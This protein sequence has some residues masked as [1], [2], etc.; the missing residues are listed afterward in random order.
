[1]QVRIARAAAER[2]REL[3]DVDEARRDTDLTFFID[4]HRPELE[5][6]A[7]R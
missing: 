2:V 3:R 1:V 7:C 4:A 6:V 5:A